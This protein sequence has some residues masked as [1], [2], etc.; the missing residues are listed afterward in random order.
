LKKE[1]KEQN[2]KK[3]M[4]FTLSFMLIV[5]ISLSFIEF[6]V[7][8]EVKSLVT[9]A[10]PLP[11]EIK[12]FVAESHKAQSKKPSRTK[13]P[14]Q[15]KNPTN[16]SSEALTDNKPDE[17]VSNPF[18][19]SGGGQE[20]GGGSNGDGGGG[21]DNGGSGGGGYGELVR[22]NAPLPNQPNTDYSGQVAV[23]LTVNDKGVVISAKST[24]G[25]THP[26][27]NVI[28]LVV[29]HVKKNVKFKAQLG[30]PIRTAYYTVQ[31]DAG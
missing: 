25:T 2:K 26:D 15:S 28:K 30:A 3:S 4:I 5:L 14:S 17:A 10:P 31:I 6:R 9:V 12:N 13:K 7:P 23:L 16:N 20:F 19:G 27:Q 21:G 8:H 18:G 22:L 11:Q 29:D 24:N 1:K